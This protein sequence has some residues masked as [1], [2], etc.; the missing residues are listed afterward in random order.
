VEVGSY[1]EREKENVALVLGLLAA[2]AAVAVG[3]VRE[4]TTWTLPTTTALPYGIAAAEDGKVCF[5]EFR[6]NKVAQLD[7]V[8][9]EIR[10]RTVGQ[11]PSALVLGDSGSMFLT[12]ALDNAV[13]FLVFIGGSAS[14]SV[15]T[16]ASWPHKLVAAPTGPGKVN[17][18]FSERETYKVARFAPAQVLVTLPLI[19]SPAT[20]VEPTLAQLEP[21][22]TTV[23]AEFYPGNPMLPPPIALLTSAT[24]GPFT[25][26]ASMI[27]DRYVERVA[28]APDGRIWFTQGMAPLS[29]LDPETSTVLLYGIPPGT[30]ALGITVAPDGWVWFTDTARASI[31]VLDP[32][33]SNIRL[34]SIPGGHQPFEILLDDAGKV[35]FTDREADMIGYLNPTTN[36]IV[37]YRLPSG[38]HPLF[39]AFDAQGNVWFTAERGNFVGR[40]SLVPVL[41]EPTVAPGA[42]FTFTGY[43]LSQRNDLAQVRFSYLYDGS[44]GLPLFLTVEVLAGGAPLAGFVSDPLYVQVSSTGAGQANFELRYTG[45][46]PRT[47][48]AMRFV[49][50]R[51]P[52]GPPT[53]VLVVEFPTTWVR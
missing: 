44:A 7:P 9:K 34:W 12:L 40:L 38:C 42:G 21:T 39:F 41:G 43:A 1:A 50:A 2:W 23:S 31:G 53:A 48:A 6:L 49:A 25:E 4:L 11:G 36:E 35:W 17:L 29:V 13:Q 47:S 16:P 22:V 30:S 8:T 37:T 24:S 26:W 46:V 33:I 51:T 18:W 27:P 32:A 5:T 14:W 52:G 10:E 3:Q 20:R 28:V 19:V 45:P 15:P